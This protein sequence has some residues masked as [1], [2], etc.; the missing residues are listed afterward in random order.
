MDLLAKIEKIDKFKAELDLLG[1]LEQDAKERLM[2]KI[3]MEWNYHSN[4]IEGNTLT[5]GETR[6]LLISGLT[7]NG[8]PLKDHLDM[9]GHNEALKK[10]EG[11]ADREVKITESLIK[12]FHDII[13]VDPFKEHP[14]VLK[15]EYKKRENYLYNAQGERVDFTPAKEVAEKLNEL[16]N[17]T[18]NAIF[19]PK[20]K[21]EKYTTHPLLIA[22]IFHMRFIN[23]HPFDDGNG[24]ICRI[25]MNIILIQ[26]G[27]PPII[28]KNEE[29][30]AYFRHIQL[31]REQGEEKL[32][33]FLADG[34][35]RS[36]ELYIS[37]AKGEP[38][39][40]PDD[41]QKRIKMLNMR[42]KG[43]GSQKIKVAKSDE[44][45]RQIIEKCWI[46]IIKEINRLSSEVTHWFFSNEVKLSVDG[47]NV[48]GIDDLVHIS[49]RS[50]IHIY[51]DGFKKAGAEPINMHSDISIQFEDFSYCIFYRKQTLYNKPYDVLLTESEI[52]DAANQVI[53]EIIE[54][55]DRT[56]ERLEKDGI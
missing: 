16:I 54:K 49:G 42:I 5:Y 44:K 12:E 27:Y 22:T 14:D 45:V 31:A 40:E 15:G 24:R 38:I 17:W 8:K 46:P 53:N 6:S 4:V 21:K 1:S 50:S 11:M 9:K 55:V 20:R 10:L 25:F 56:I 36:L 18:N 19:L 48:S 7:A 13:L 3:R 51:F 23:I 32:A 52:K 34:L 47:R 41:L 2:Q 33:E 26:C 28:I 37:A 35:I 43:L 30:E 29:R 39:E